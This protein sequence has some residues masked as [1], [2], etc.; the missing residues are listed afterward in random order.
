MTDA[1]GKHF[2]TKEPGPDDERFLVVL[3]EGTRVWGTVYADDAVSA[4]TIGGQW[5]RGEYQ[6]LID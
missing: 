6:L 2:V 5:E 4:S 3:M 1:T